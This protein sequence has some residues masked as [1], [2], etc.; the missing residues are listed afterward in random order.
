MMQYRWNR[1]PSESPLC[2]KL[3][4]SVGGAEYVDLGAQALPQDE[5]GLEALVALLSREAA[6]PSTWLEVGLEYLRG[7]GAPARGATGLD[8]FCTVAAAFSTLSGT[9]AVRAPY[10]AVAAQ[11]GAAYREAAARGPDAEIAA[12][13]SLHVAFSSA[14]MFQV[15]LPRYAARVPLA[16]RVLLHVQASNTAALAFYRHAGFRIEEFLPEYYHFDSHVPD[17]LRTRFDWSSAAYLLSAPLDPAAPEH[18]SLAQCWACISGLFSP[19]LSSSGFVVPE[20]KNG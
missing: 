14:L 11:H 4:N 3:K 12:A 17:D 8:L 7:P 6:P 5:A 18:S 15:A 20:E 9:D 13:C 1:D 16:S 2:V 10:P 19:M